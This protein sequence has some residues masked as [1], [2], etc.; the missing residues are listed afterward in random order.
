MLKLYNINERLNKIYIYIMRCVG[1]YTL[2]FHPYHL[3][4]LMVQRY[5]KNSI[6]PRELHSLT[7][8]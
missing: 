6:L 5:E 2:E 8:I 7:I 3:Y 4:F 1:D